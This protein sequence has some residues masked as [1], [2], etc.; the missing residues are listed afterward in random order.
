MIHL[1]CASLTEYLLSVAAHTKASDR[2]TPPT[3]TIV[4]GTSLKSMKIRSRDQEIDFMSLRTVCQREGRSH[5][6]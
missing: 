5:F 1:L 6:G 4:Q 2:A 3:R